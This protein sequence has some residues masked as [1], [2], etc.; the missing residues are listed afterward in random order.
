MKRFSFP[1]AVLGL[2]FLFPAFV[3]CQATRSEKPV[4]LFPHLVQAPSMQ[5]EAAALF[6]EMGGEQTF[7][8]LVRYLYRWYL[9]E[10]DFKRFRPDVKRQ[11]WIRRVQAVADQGDKSRY[12]EVVFPAIGVRITLKKTDYQIPELKLT[13]RSGGY[14]VIQ[15][16]RDADLEASQAADYAALDLNIAAL[17]DRLYKMRL[18]RT[19]PDET[20]QTH[21]QKRIVQQCDQWAADQRHKPKT[22]Y[23]APV[24]AVDNEC[25]VFWEEGRRLFK[26]SSEIDLANP[27]VWMHDRLDVVVCDT[28]TQTIVSFEERPGDNSCF[29]RDQIGRA[30]YNCVVL[31]QRRVAP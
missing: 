25:W 8:D 16:S 5:S 12:L 17:Y 24:H 18:E 21:I 15:L 14:R 29:T 10:D 2:L 23:V 3:G 11:L 31:G 4:T 6:T 30:L 9:D 26:F 22:L 13:V 27:D 7:L 1:S 19:F 28:V 20:L